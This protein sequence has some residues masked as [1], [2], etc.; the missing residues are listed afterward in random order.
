MRRTT[1]G[2][3]MAL[4]LA[5]AA[6]AVGCDDDDED[7][8]GTGT[9]AVDVFG[10]AFIEEGIPAGTAG[11]DGC[12]EDGWAITFDRFLIVVQDIEVRGAETVAAPEARV[13]DLAKP[14]S[15]GGHRV[16]D[17]AAAAGT[18]D[19]L[20]YR[21]APSREPAVGNATT[22]D[23]ALMAAEGYSIY[24]EGR[25][26]K[27]GTTLTFNWGFDTDTRYTACETQ[28]T[29]ADGGT[30]RS[31]LTIHADHLLYD[32]LD[33]ETPQVVF[34]LIASADADG[35]GAIT[36][37]ELAAVDITGETRYQVGSR[38][39]TDLWGFLGA[40]AHT[41]GHIDGEGHCDFQPAE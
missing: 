12:V 21:V 2:L 39:I 4:A 34:G 11:C 23:V 37:A 24:V 10:E 27:D 32:D 28:A 15:G 25:A 8:A 9:L 31:Q 29:V 17:R 26:E 41:V 20:D 19:A 40:Q 6:T 22:D 14:S 36:P 38:D 3:A 13:F 1:T 7:A 16:F 35:D 18:Y 30:G 33:S 5:L